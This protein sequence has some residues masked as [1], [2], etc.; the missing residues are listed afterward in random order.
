MSVVQKAAQEVF[1][2]PPARAKAFAE[3]ICDCFSYCRQK[4][5]NSKTGVKLSEPVRQVVKAMFGTDKL[6]D[7]SLP[8]AT[9]TPS[10]A[11]STRSTSASTS[12]IAVVLPC[13]GSLASS[14]VSAKSQAEVFALYGLSPPPAADKPKHG[15]VEVLS[16]Q[17][18]AS[19]Q[20]IDLKVKETTSLAPGSSTD[21]PLL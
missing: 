2:G 21:S 8:S 16:S 11:G 15:C 20:E 19:S 1:G 14:H 18:V 6:Q 10:M 17:E 9:R 3:H 12:S 4:G 13:V 7:P 5:V